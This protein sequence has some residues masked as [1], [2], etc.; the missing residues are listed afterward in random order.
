VSDLRQLTHDEATELAGLYVLDALEPAE[1]EA[2]RRHLAEC[3]EEHPE[4]DEVGGVVPA[5]AGMVEPLD[6]PVELRSQV[7]AA[8]AA[9]AWADAQEPAKV[10]DMEPD[11]SVGRRL[12]AA[13][14]A[15]VHARRPAWLGWAAAAAAVLLIAALGALSVVLQA[16]TNELERRSALIAEAIAASTAEG[17]EVATLRGTGPAGGASG[18]AAFTPEG[19]GYILLVGLPPA[20]VGQ[21]YHAWYLVDGRPFSAGVV[22]V[23]DDGYALL[24]GLEPMPGTDLIAFTTERAGG[25]D[26]PTSDPIVSGQ[27]GA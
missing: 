3:A 5:L 27:L 9:E 4:F 22:S 14:S 7:M 6:A 16:R 23:G 26:E 1:H 15:P 20:P 2:V 18:F 12:P 19:E 10:W 24:T 25:A 21:T 11:R 8:I 13:D 17:A